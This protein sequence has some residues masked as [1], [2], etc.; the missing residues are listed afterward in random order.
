MKF[1]LGVA[2]SPLD[3]LAGLART[4]EECGFASIALPDSL[5]YMETAAAKYPYTPDGSRMWNAD[6]PW[7]DPLIAAA[8][9]AA[10]T[11]SIRF[12]TNV[13]KL[14]CATLCCWRGRWVP[15]PT[16]RGTGSASASA[17]AGR[18]R[19]SCGAARPMNSE[20]REWTR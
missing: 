13:L 1:T 6:T 17:S 12:Y 4:A 5:F 19:S 16:S 15:S 11:S 20:A 2:M 9:M 10:V 18:P 8:A 3:Q 14:G 7:A